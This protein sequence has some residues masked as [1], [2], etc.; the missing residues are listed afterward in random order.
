MATE[1]EKEKILANYFKGGENGDDDD[2]PDFDPSDHGE[3]SDP[4]EGDGDSDDDGEEEE[5]SVVQGNDDN[6]AVL[7]G[8]IQLNDEGDRLVYLGT[9]YMKKDIDAAA[10]AAKEED[11]KD[12]D[13][14]DGGDKSN[15]G[16]C[17]D[18]KKCHRQHYKKKKTKFKYKSKQIITPQELSLDMNGKK[19]KKRPAVFDLTNPTVPLHRIK[20]DKTDSPQAAVVIP[21]K[22]TLLFDGFFLTSEEEGYRKI[23]ERDLEITFLTEEGDGRTIRGSD[24]N[25]SPDSASDDNVKN[26]TPI[27]QFKVLGSGTNEFGGFA[28]DGT[29]AVNVSD[30]SDLP[31]TGVTLICN[32]RYR[33]VASA[34]S[35]SRR[36]RTRGW[37]EDEQ[38]LEDDEMSADD[39]ADYNE[40]IALNEEANMSVE[41]LRRRY[42]GG[43]LAELD[44]GEPPSKKMRAD[45]SAVDDSDDEGCGF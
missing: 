41:E 7:D 42:Y 32:K 8:R 17:D 38:D 1:E 27:R 9:W 37:S 45:F 44:S 25:S 39:V 10:G 16:V 5:E 29:Y 14:G 11:K 18:K 2:G 35:Q 28:I 36:R 21:P 23:K 26:S 22:R 33:P 3:D 20:R 6:Y 31:S 15:T 19:E 30:P 13:V 34:G 12:G 40:L 4:F 24:S 43:G